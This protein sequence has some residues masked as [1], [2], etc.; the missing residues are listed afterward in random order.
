MNN[1]TNAE[2]YRK[3]W[4]FSKRERSA[5]EQRPNEDDSASASAEQENAL[6]LPTPYDQRYRYLHRQSPREALNVAGGDDLSSPGPT[7]S[8]TPPH[9]TTHHHTPSHATTHTRSVNFAVLSAK[10]PVMIKDEAFQEV[11]K[12]LHLYEDFRQKEKVGKPLFLSL[13]LSLPLFLFVGGSTRAQQRTHATI[14][15]LDDRHSSPRCSRSRASGPA[16]RLRNTARRS[17]TPCGT[18]RSLSSPATPVAAY[19]SLALLALVVVWAARLQLGV[20][21]F[22]HS[23]TTRLSCALACHTE[24]DAG[25]PVPAERRH[26]QDR[27]HAAATD[28]SHVPLQASRL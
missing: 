26:A 23:L 3:Y 18:T 5:K 6:G 2:F 13:S 15:F 7:P 11:K 17:S 24:I 4:Q 22:L 21:F 20:A 9:S 10:G 28:S 12:A 27:L 25:V 1:Y 16:C 14:D 8:H 19:V